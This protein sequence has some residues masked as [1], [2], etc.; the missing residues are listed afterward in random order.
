MG[1]SSIWVS[2]DALS[3]C[4]DVARE[5]GFDIF[6]YLARHGIDP[7]L[8][9]NSRGLLSYQAIGDCLEDIAASEGCADF[10]FELGKHQKPLQFGMISQVLQFAPDVGT[11]IRIFL[12]YR[13]LYS[14]SSYWGLS[15]EDDVARLRRQELGA[16]ASRRPQIVLLSVTRGFEAIRS[17]MGPGWSPLAVYLTI[18]ATPYLPALRRYFGAPVF[19]DAAFDE[20]AFDAADLIQPIPTGNEAILSALTEYFD[21]LIPELGGKGAIAVQ[22]QKLM[23]LE[24]ENGGVSLGSVARHFAMHPRSLQRALAVEGTS[25]RELAQETRLALASQMVQT[26]RAQLSEVAEAAGYRH[27]SSLSRAYKRSRGKP[28]SHHRGAGTRTINSS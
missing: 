2:A 9:E 6:P 4:M 27:L 12:K 24:L 7:D 5:K 28:P 20:I 15:I 16:S 23:R 26:S 18:E 21:R 1:T 17:M 8:I 13:D 25:F 22:V 3:G 11:A 10:G 14:Q 19:F